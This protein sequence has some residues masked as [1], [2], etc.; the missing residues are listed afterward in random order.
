MMKPGNKK[1]TF[2]RRYRREQEAKGMEN[3]IGIKNRNRE[4]E[5][6]IGREGNGKLDEK[7]EAYSEER[8]RGKEY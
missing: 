6:R 8:E 2:R 3:R 7:Q 5:Q 4:Q 1:K